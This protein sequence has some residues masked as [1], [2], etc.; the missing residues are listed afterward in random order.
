MK[1]VVGN[2]YLTRG[3]RVTV[4][5]I[6]TDADGPYPVLGLA[7][8]GDDGPTIVIRFTPEG[9]ARSGNEVHHLDLIDIVVMPKVNKYTV[10]H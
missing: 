7:D 3:G 9:R 5:I 4:E 10:R 1:P 6:K 8:Y 2:N